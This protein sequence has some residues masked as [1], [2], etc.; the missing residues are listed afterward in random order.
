MQADY[1]LEYN[2]LSMEKDHR[3]Y[4]LARIKAQ[5]GQ[6]NAD[7]R[8]LNLSVVIDRSGSMAGDKLD[9]VKKAAQF[10]VKHL[11]GKD[12]LSIVTYD[13]SVK[14]NVAPGPVVHKDRINSSVHKIQAGGTTN[15]SGGWL[16]GCQLVDEHTQ[17]G[18][19]NRVLLLSDGLANQGVTD[20]DRLE[21]MARQKR[22]QGITT[23]TMG[24]G[25]DFNEDLLKRMAA[26]GGGAFYFIDNPDQAPAI[27]NEELQDLM[28]VVGQNLIVTLTPTERVDEINQLNAY[29][30][31]KNGKVLQFQMGD[32]YAD[33]IK[34]LVLEL[35]IPA[36]KELG[37]IEVARLKFDYDE[38]E[39][40]HSTTH[41]TLE[42]PI[43]INAVSDMSTA[44]Q[45]PNLEVLKTALLLRAARAREDAIK[46]AD[47]GEFKSASDILKN[48]ASE[49]EEA[50]IEDE[51]LQTQH[52][53]LHEE[54]VDMEL[55]SQR[56]D[57][58]TR[59]A[60]TTKTVFSDR[61]DRYSD[62]TQ[63]LHMRLKKSRRAIERHE[64]VPTVLR[65]KKEEVE[66][67]GVEL[68]RIGRAG[69]NDVVL[70]EKAISKYHCQISREDGR[71]YLEDLQSKNGTFANGGQVAPG[72]RFELSR[73]DVVTIGRTLFRLE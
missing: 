50:E 60:H 19:T 46:Q 17:K 1:V 70:E 29:P 47:Q 10:L 49:I 57:S 24:V 48:M 37:E 41:R 26:A 58:Y 65:W 34:T 22:E 11:A 71:L 56:Y 36:L 61:Y 72:K 12:M 33:E 51:D 30:T 39:S 18:Q 62:Q 14:V 53:M 27:F 21:G 69:D 68:L 67:D 73:G 31:E 9:Y 6:Q 4:L 44:A 66:L 38:L 42:L 35:S 54:A 55:G 7:R 8:V 63:A 5:P 64:D 25:M 16:Q 43:I 40:E 15:L 3:L 59:K 45:S 52:D 13:Q 2:V 32:L 20:T 28:N 23:T